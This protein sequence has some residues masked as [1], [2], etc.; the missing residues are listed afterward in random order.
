MINHFVRCWRVCAAVMVLAV[1]SCQTLLA[2]EPAV[3]KPAV[4]V[5]NE[6]GANSIDFPLLRSFH[7][8]EGYQFDYM[9]R[10]EVL[11]WDRL[12]KYNA[13]VVLDPYFSTKDK[14]KP[15]AAALFT[16]LEKFMEEGGG[17]LF[18]SS[19]E[20]TGSMC[21]SE[22]DVS[23]F[24]KLLM[25]RFGISYLRQQA[26]REKSD[27]AAL[28]F[29]FFNEQVFYTENI[30]PHPV[31]QEVKGIWYPAVARDVKWS[32]GTRGMPSSALY[33]PE[34]WQVLV[35]GSKT[36]YTTVEDVRFKNIACAEAMSKKTYDA[37][38]PL[39]AVRDYKKGRMAMYV[40]NPKF[41]WVAGTHRN[42]D[43][44]EEAMRGGIVLEKGA[45]GK[46]SHFRRLLANTV[47]WLSAPSLENGKLGGYVQDQAKLNDPV[48]PPSRVSA[49]NDALISEW[50]KATTPD[51]TTAWR[52]MIGARTE[53]SGAK[54]TVA[55]Y[56]TSAKKAGLQYLV[57]LETFEN[58]TSDKL[59]DLKN[60]CVKNSDDQF[61][62]IPGLYVKDNRG[63]NQH[64]F[65]MT[66]VWPAKEFLT[67]DGKMFDVQ[68]R[69]KTSGLPHIG[70][71]LSYASGKNTL[72][73]FGFTKSKISAM[74]NMKMYNSSGLVLYEGG[75][76]TEG[77]KEN[78]E[79]YL[80]VQ[81][82]AGNIQPLAIDLLD[83]PAMLDAAVKD[84]HLLT[85]VSAKTL[86]DVPSAIKY[87]YLWYPASFISSGPV[88]ADW[89]CANR[90]YE[91]HSEN[92]LTPNY[93]FPVRLH[94]K[95][96]VGLR[97][98]KIWDGLKPSMRI[99]LNGEKD[100]LQVFMFNHDK[101]KN[102]VLEVRDI[103][104]GVAVSGEQFDRNHMNMHYTCSDRINGAYGR[105]P[106]FFPGVTGEKG[107]N[108]VGKGMDSFDLYAAP[109]RLGHRN[110]ESSE[111]KFANGR[112]STRP[113]QELVSEDI[114]WLSTRCSKFFPETEKLWGPWG[115]YG[116][117]V[118]T[119]LYD[120]RIDYMS[121]RS[122]FASAN[123]YNPTVAGISLQGDISP[124]IS[125]STYR[126]KQDQ[127]LKS[128]PVAVF[129][130]G[131]YATIPGNE[132]VL[133]ICQN[134]KSE[135]ISDIFT[136]NS[137]SLSFKRWQALAKEKKTRIETK[138]F[139]AIHGTKPGASTVI[140]YNVG[141]TPWLVD[142]SDNLSL[143]A[144]VEGRAV[145]SG[146]EIKISILSVN[147]R[148]P[149]LTGA[150]RYKKLADYMGLDGA[151]AYKMNLTRGKQLPVTIG[152]CD[153]QSQNG[154]VEFSMEKSKQNLQLVLPVRVMG[155]ND[156]WSAFCYDKLKKQAR[157][158]G[159]YQGIGYARFDPDYNQ[160]I[161]T[162]VGHPVVADNNDV[163]ILFSV[164]G[165]GKYPVRKDGMLCYDGVYSLQVNNPTDKDLTVTLKKNMDLPGFPFETK[166]VNLKAGELLEIIKN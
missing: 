82:A 115:T 113:L 49:P 104:G 132:M 47:Q 21:D 146:E 120:L 108:F 77:L 61:L 53:L 75:K 106:L 114:M 136:Q 45:L 19:V 154:A 79:S 162:A 55:D 28:R 62:C 147:G 88:I 129:R 83:S 3:R 149:D 163:V 65:G 76:E 111:G 63:N 92:Y 52:G 59:D 95:S 150:W 140:F 97:E 142:F 11:T 81:N 51:S 86:K 133:C 137:D 39:F 155:M 31:T 134:D 98:I 87:E 116:P 22:P 46:P 25:E 165:D 17:V 40:M 66:I 33:A 20:D 16:L 1:I 5:L 73:Y 14:E 103:N 143:M 127:T 90:D 38:P 138:G 151:P 18:D 26:L 101:Q 64:Y 112:P 161:D 2:A 71:M 48:A 10:R 57:F 70:F 156:K 37:S 15:S 160:K 117:L 7:L 139:F 157:P 110:F 94:V 32:A 91:G 74:W 8:R 43:G 118:D 131:P 105:G 72:G 35:S 23:Q 96:E 89:T 121:F 50:R 164:L 60:Q 126:F 4:L 141:E 128:L 42:L 36:A 58:M 68:A 130:M 107:Y 12:E 93:L 148:L 119:T 24:T 85:Y 13:V 44:D 152:L 80:E 6:S 125:T 153:L 100:F 166:T 34:P 124:A 109:E 84:K 99:G 41:T 30:T 54:G 144:D 78:L 123:P 56:A 29:G 69:E 67:E 158:I 27:D 9:G 159:V 135:P 145:K 122:H 102:L